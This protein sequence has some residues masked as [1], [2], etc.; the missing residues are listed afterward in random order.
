L[1]YSAAGTRV[2]AAVARASARNGPQ[3]AAR[4]SIAGA[5]PPGR[6]LGS[7]WIFLMQASVRTVSVLSAFLLAAPL[8][9]HCLDP[10]QPQ[11]QQ[12]K[13]G[14]PK[15]QQAAPASQVRYGAEGLPAPV[16]E[17]REAILAAVKSGK[18]DELGEVY[19]HSDLKPDLG[20]D[21]QGDPVAHWKRI[22]GDGQ[23]REV[24]AAL[25]LALEAGYVV[26]P[27]GTDLENNRLYVWPYFA[28]VPLHSLTPAQEVELLRLVSPSAAQEMKAK[29]KYAHWRLVI[30]A[31]G[32]WHAFRKNN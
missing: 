21:P 4:A 5:P 17:T 7:K 8:L 13:P 20:A 12:A 23:G 22:S 15:K 24:L 1:S 25:W 10:A 14:S 3:T 31:D 9:V 29:G 19:E 30:G 11:A 26:V 2:R 28:D 32:S 16:R 6:R 27:L 18:I